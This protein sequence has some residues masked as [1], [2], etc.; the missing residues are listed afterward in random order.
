MRSDA[1]QHLTSSH[2]PA[3]ARIRL[4]TSYLCVL[5]YFALAGHATA[6][7]VLDSVRNTVTD[8]QTNLVWDH[9]PYGRDGANCQ[10]GSPTQANWVDALNIVVA[11]NQENYRGYGDWRLPNRTE[12]E[13]LVLRGSLY[14]TSDFGSVANDSVVF[15]LS[16]AV[17]FWTST[18]Y[19]RG[20]DSAWHVDF[21][22]GGTHPVRKTQADFMHVR[23]VRGGDA[24]DGWRYC[25]PDLDGDGRVLP[26]T[27][28]LIHARI[29]RGAT[30]A[31]AIANIV[32]PPGSQR[33]T[34]PA[35]R[36]Y[37]NLHCGANLP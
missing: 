8:T 9:C 4:S 6:A 35:I 23:L 17:R 13:S 36:D 29:N 20:P 21:Q 16:Y 7:F 1:L 37:L 15:P 2:A 5:A 11:A 34:W 31:A 25:S 33:Q 27:D 24:F 12:L 18:S 26:T 28:G 32:F 30:G 14:H 22:T 3:Y 19:A 10:L